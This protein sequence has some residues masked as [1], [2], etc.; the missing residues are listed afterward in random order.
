MIHPTRISVSGPLEVFAPGFAS[1]LL[2]QG[3]TLNSA[4][5]QMH[6]MVHLSRWLAREGLDAGTLSTTE[7]ERFL[8]VRRAAGFTNHRTSKAMRPLLAYLRALGAA[9][10]PAI[11]TPDGPVQVAL[12]RYRSYLTVDRGLAATTA[13][14]YAHAVRPFLC[15]TLLS[16]GANLDFRHLTTADITAFVVAR[17]AH[18]S[19][20]AA[21]LTVTALRSLLGFLHV[22]GVIE[23][24]LVAAVPSIAGRCLV[25][26]PKGLEPAQVRRLLDS[27]DRRTR[28]G[29]RDFAI[30]TLLVRLGLRIGEA[31]ALSLDDIEWRTGEVVVHGKGKRV[32]RLPLPVDVGEAV[33][34][35]LRR[36]RPENAE[37]RSVF[38]R[39][40]APHRALRPSGIA[41]VV[42]AA[43]QRAGLTQIHAHRLR[44]TTATQ[45]LR[46]GASLPEIGQLLRHRRVLTTAIYAKVDREALRMIAR[47]WPGGVA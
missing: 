22:E 17:C 7:A 28:I 20:G 16:D 14:G 42:L 38:V 33:A 46:A 32:D 23:R 29:R 26:L 4:R 43:A 8:S 15:D 19:G 45:L 31:A 21:K 12:E 37:G 44:H 1:E 47:P 41:S 35:Y 30:L 25:G 6:L 27:C 3:Y 36:G 10:S 40:R 9:P 2:R 11:S 39:V 13:R 18:Q 24:P 34:A 5:L